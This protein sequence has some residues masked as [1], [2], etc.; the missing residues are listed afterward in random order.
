MNN[1]NNDHGVDGGITQKDIARAIKSIAY[2]KAYNQR[3]DVRAARKEYSV[4]RSRRIKMAMEYIK[5]H[6]EVVA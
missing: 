1:P 3:A 2:R 5:K 4:E 6:P